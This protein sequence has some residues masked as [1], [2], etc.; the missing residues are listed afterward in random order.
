ML[1]KIQLEMHVHCTTRVQKTMLAEQMM[2][3]VDS[4]V[5]SAQRTLHET[6]RTYSPRSTWAADEPPEVHRTPSRPLLTPRSRPRPLP[7]VRATD[8]NY[9][10]S[11]WPQSLRFCIHQCC[12]KGQC[13]MLRGR[14]TTYN[15][16]PPI[17]YHCLRNHCT[18]PMV[19][20]LPKL[21]YPTKNKLVL[22]AIC[23][24]SKKLYH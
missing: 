19:S 9:C 21:S 18:L 13:L 12:L 15:R 17:P 1:L 8:T 22:C 5:Q 3:E 11:N 7:E 6:G 20:P 24:T 10:I 16:R 2:A 23:A 4:N 14:Q